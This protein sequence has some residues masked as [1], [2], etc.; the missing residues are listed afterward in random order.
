[1]G[2]IYENARRVFIY[3][4]EEDFHSNLA[5]AYLSAIEKREIQFDTP[6][7]PEVLEALTLFLARPWFSRIWVLQEVYQA[8]KAILLCGTE[9]VSW[10]A[11]QTLR[12]FENL[13]ESRVKVWPYVATVKGGKLL[14]AYQL[15]ALLTET[16]GCHVTDPRDKLFALLPL[17]ADASNCGLAADYA[18]SKTRIFFKVAR[19]LAVTSGLGFLSDVSCDSSITENHDLP[20]WVPDWTTPLNRTPLSQIGSRSFWGAGREGDIEGKWKTACQDYVQWATESPLGFMPI[21]DLP[22]VVSQPHL[23]VPSLAIGEIETILPPANL[24]EKSWKT[25][26]REWDEVAQHMSLSPVSFEHRFGGMIDDDDI[27]VLIPSPPRRPILQALF[28]EL[29]HPALSTTLYNIFESMQDFTYSDKGLFDREHDVKYDEWVS[30]VER[31]IHGR[32]FF[33]TKN[34]FFGVAVGEACE[35]DSIMILATGPVPYVFRGIDC[36]HSWLE[37]T[38][39]VC[40]LIGDCYLAGAMTGRFV[41]NVVAQQKPDAPDF[42]KLLHI[43]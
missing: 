31:V 4:G 3:L 6:T 33:R 1:M 7:T 13:R 25:I 35:G 40:S 26:L 11:I 27:G 15:Y 32:R 30:R 22:Y 43:C 8:K 19:Y 21:R 41:Q 17:L 16:R 39:S 2:S 10:D 36:R 24:K 28:M 9:R 20:S 38:P 12:Y 18:L 14:K 34:G 42:I 5:M 29:S 23:S 37:P